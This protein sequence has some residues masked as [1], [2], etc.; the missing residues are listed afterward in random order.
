[1]KQLALCISRTALPEHKDNSIGIYPFELQDI[2]NDQFHL[3][4]REVCDTKTT[5]SKHFAVAQALP[6]ILGYA[7][8]T[9]GDEVLTYS[10]SK[11]GGEVDLHAKRS[12]GFGGHVDLGDLTEAADVFDGYK[13]AVCSAISREM[14]EELNFL[15]DW[16]NPDS[17]TEIL[18]DTTNVVGM[19]HVGLPIFFDISNE[20]QNIE[21]NHEIC[22]P[23]WVSK[24]DLLATVDQYE[25]WSQILINRGIYE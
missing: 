9:R 22:D 10:R 25:N 1:M 4:N 16:P 23:R 19:A 2:E 21:A 24:A 3:I 8:I 11:T 6:Q 15:I 7:V 14:E 20:D 12:I 5:S 13:G 17:F 18:I